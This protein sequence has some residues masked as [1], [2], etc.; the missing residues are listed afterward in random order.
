MPTEAPQR[1]GSQPRSLPPGDTG[2][3][4]ETLVEVGGGVGGWGRGWGWGWRGGYL[5]VEASD[6]PESSLD[7]RASTAENDLA[8]QSEKSCPK[9]KAGARRGSPGLITPTRPSF[10][11]PGRRLL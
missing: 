10:L 1:S 3:C 9:G 8:W 7:S 2:Q 5:D 6:A 4:L 11:S